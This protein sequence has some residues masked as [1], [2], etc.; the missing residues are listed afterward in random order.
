MES[1]MITFIFKWTIAVGK[2]LRLL[3]KL[4]AV[5]SFFVIFQ[6]I[7]SFAGSEEKLPSMPFVPFATQEKHDFHLKDR[8]GMLY[9]YVVKSSHFSD[10][11]LPFQL[12]I[13]TTCGKSYEDWQQSETID[14]ESA[15]EILPGSVQLSKDENKVSVKLRKRDAKFYEKGGNDGG[16]PR[17]LK[18]YTTKIFDISLESG[19]CP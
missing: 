8:R 14:S 3:R 11:G 9:V 12:Q 19:V 1:T 15:C 4:N 10:Q 13:K 17:C 18:N 16:T 6:S 7:V 5:L 2:N